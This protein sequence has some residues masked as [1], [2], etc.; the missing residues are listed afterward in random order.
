MSW[1]NITSHQS[2]WEP[3]AQKKI[4]RQKLDP[5]FCDAWVFWKGGIKGK[6]FFMWKVNPPVAPDETKF[7]Y[8]LGACVHQRHKSIFLLF[9]RFWRLRGAWKCFLYSGLRRVYN[10]RHFFRLLTWR[11]PSPRL[12]TIWVEFLFDGSLYYAQDHPLGI[13]LVYTFTNLRHSTF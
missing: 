4:E 10:K 7:T 5:D 8:L 3:C 1:K 11:C 12:L 2:V 9:T 6:P 13:S